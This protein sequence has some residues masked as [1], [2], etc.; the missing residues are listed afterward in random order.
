M[1]W[2]SVKKKKTTNDIKKLTNCGATAKKCPHELPLPRQGLVQPRQHVPHIAGGG[3][4]PQLNGGVGGG[5]VGE[6]V[7]QLTVEGS[8][9][10]H[11]PFFHH[12]PNKKTWKN[13]CFQVPDEKD[14]Q[15]RIKHLEKHE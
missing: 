7:E 3:V 12:Q 13:T 2:F 11:H 10:H 9:P 5:Q 4:G 14:E 6:G 1:L 8:S 15:T